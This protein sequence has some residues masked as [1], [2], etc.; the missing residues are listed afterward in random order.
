MEN[1]IF[2]YY[3]QIALAFILYILLLVLIIQQVAD[4]LDFQPLIDNKIMIL[5]S[6]LKTLNLSLL[7][8]VASVVS[9]FII[10]LM[11][12]SKIVFIHFV[13]KI[14]KEIIMGTPLLVMVF[15]IVYIIGPAF[16]IR[17][18]IAL[19]FFS[20][21]L[22]MSPYM[23]NIY[24]GA[25]KTIDNNQFMIMDLYGFNSYQKYYYFILPQMIRP[26]VPGLINSLSSIVK[27]TSIL[28][29][30]AVTEIFYTISILSNQ[31]YRYI[32]GYFVLWLVYLVITIPLSLLAQF[33]TKRWEKIK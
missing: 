9:G 27:G 19:G 16:G 10:F 25:Y 6:A 14:F 8:L 4:I 24:E 7:A 3:I 13:A 1:N 2:K 31:T 18:K 17:E 5:E 20:L 26:I 30:I 32:E 22:Y 28:S 11:T 29:T 21:T 15:V 23:A 12:E 33:F